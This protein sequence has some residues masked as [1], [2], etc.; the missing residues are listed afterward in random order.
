M[1]KKGSLNF[2]AALKHFLSF[3]YDENEGFCEMLAYSQRYQ[4][5]LQNIDP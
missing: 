5:H 2:G 3:R 4:I 1:T